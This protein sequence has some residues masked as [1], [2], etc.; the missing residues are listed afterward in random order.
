MLSQTLESFVRRC[1]C[2]LHVHVWDLR[3]GYLGMPHCGSMFPFSSVGTLMFLLADLFLS[4][5][6]PVMHYLFLKVRYLS[7]EPCDT[8][9]II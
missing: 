3:V 8:E 5:A 7:A 2:V 6:V 9:A 1:I 4:C